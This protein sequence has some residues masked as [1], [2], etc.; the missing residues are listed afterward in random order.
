[1][2]AARD[3]G[4]QNLDAI[5]EREA[6]LVG[7]SAELGKTY[8]RENLHFVLG[9]RERAGLRR[10]YELCVKHGIAPSGKEAVLEDF[11]EAEACRL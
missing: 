1:M 2:R 10:F 5:A 4:L 9:Q 6:P 3:H 8:F 11:G 7:V